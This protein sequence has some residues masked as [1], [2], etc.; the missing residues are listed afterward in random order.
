MHFNKQRA[1]VALLATTLTSSLLALDINAVAEAKYSVANAKATSL[2]NSANDTTHAPHF[3]VG[4]LL[5]EYNTRALI[6]YKPI[7][8]RDA[9]ADLVSLSLEY[10]YKADERIDLYAGAG[11]GTM[12][13]E[14]QNMKDTKTVYTLQAGANLTLIENFYA[15]L[16]VNY[17]NTNDLGIRKNQYIYSDVEDMFS[18]EIGVGLRF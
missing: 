3:S 15:I 5:N 14:A 10:I 18:A 6:N 1:I 12:R 13:Y 2:Q 8:W 7:R 17:L 4:A 16:G 11:I 9:E